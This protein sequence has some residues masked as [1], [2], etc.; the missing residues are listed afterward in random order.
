MTDLSLFQVPEPGELHPAHYFERCLRY[1]E[2]E[3]IR[4]GEPAFQFLYRTQPL[5]RGGRQVLGSVHMPTVQGQLRDVFAWM[6]EQTFGTLPDFLVILDRDYWT[7][8]TDREREILMF[9]E[10]SHVEQK[11]DK[12]GAPRIDR[13][14][15]KPVFGLV[16]HDVEEFTAVV[17][18]YG[19]WNP[20]LAAFIEAARGGTEEV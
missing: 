16:G 5:V 20:E 17:R 9:H 19:A 12:W 10:L 13:D 4:D 7:S 1:P 6:L 3:H 2:H 8:C 18:R 15:G 14:T 11:L